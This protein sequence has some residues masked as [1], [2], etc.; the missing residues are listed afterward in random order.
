MAIK[1]FN[2]S[3]NHVEDETIYQDGATGQIHTLSKRI[4]GGYICQWCHGH[5]EVYAVP[6]G[7]KDPD[8][9]GFYV[10]S[11]SCMDNLLKTLCHLKTKC[12]DELPL[13][14]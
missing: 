8:R 14:A 13:Y 5:T 1:K 4:D 10:C 7:S 12:D 11:P 3:F 2:E 9:D 6:E